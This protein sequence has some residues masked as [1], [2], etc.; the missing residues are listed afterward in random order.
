[1]VRNLA[2]GIAGRQ[3]GPHWTTRW[4]AAHKNEVKSAYLTPIDTARKKADSALYYSLYFELVGRKITEYDIQPENIYNMDEKGFLIGFLKKARRIFT[5]KAFDA[6][7]VKHVSQDGNREWITVIATICADGTSLSPGLIYQA[8]SGD[9]QDSW[10]QDYD[11]NEHSCF[12]ASSPTGWTNDDLGYAWLTTLFDRE[13]KAKARQGRDWRLLIVD[14]HGSHIN[15]RFIDYCHLHRIL[16][17]V[18]PPHSTHRLQPLDVSLF[19]PLATYYSQELNQFQLDSEGYSRLT[20]R[21][22]F[23]LF[24]VAYNKAFVEKNIQSGWEKTGLHP[25]QPEVV[26]DKFLPKEA[27]AEERPSSS[28]SSKS[29]LTAA[30]WRRI[31]RKLKEVVANVFDT[32]VKELTET[33]K[34]LAATNILL[35]SR[36]QGYQ[37]ALKNDQKKRQRQKPLFHQLAT[38]N[39]GGAIFYSPNKVQQARDLQKEQEEAKERETALKANKKLQRQLE[40]DEKR[41]LVEQRK[42]QRVLD[43]VQREREAAAKKLAA[44]EA[45]EAKQAKR[46]LQNDLKQARRS[47]RNQN[48]RILAIEE[49]E[50]D[51]GCNAEVQVAE[52]AGVRPRR[53]K[54]LPKKYTDFEL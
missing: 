45:K 39:D 24:W 15:M 53:Q 44:E 28:E 7:R 16:L 8:V 18:Y 23:R 27:A 41:R 48:N 34:S 37:R 17:A 42:E 29:V 10:L 9:I 40:K 14:G 36:I 11:P 35:E 4:L 47:K 49:V 25:F 20:K 6:G 5:K 2:A 46:Q 43:K 22:F 32:R 51:P 33:I 13:T 26:L 21:D 3:P 12:F 50:V 30:D 1:M 38:Q 31:E 54:R 19:S 52:L